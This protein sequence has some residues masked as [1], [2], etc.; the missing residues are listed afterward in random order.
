MPAYRFCR[1]DDIPLLVEAINSCYLPH[2]P[3]QTE[4]TLTHFKKDIRELNLWSSSCMIATDGSKLIAVCLGCKRKKETL[5][6]KI[7]VH[8]D[9]QRQGHGHH[10]LT[11][12]RS[13]LAV[14]GPPR[15]VVEVPKDLTQAA[16]FFKDLGYTLTQSFF[17]FTLT[18]KLPSIQ[19]TSLVSTFD[20]AELLLHKTFQDDLLS[21]QRS[22]ETLLNKKRDL[23]SIA[24]VSVDCIEAYV[25]YEQN[26]GSDNVT[27]LRF[28]AAEGATGT[29]ALGLLIRHLY[30]T[31]KKPFF[32]PK[33]GS[34]EISFD[35][36]ESIGFIR[37]PEY[38]SLEAWAKT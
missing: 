22:D 3:A 13:K 14:L 25:V 5:I 21:W 18:R 9:F 27:I 7:G 33:V 4:T 26:P 16:L 2:F 12:L 10:L 28:Y 30:H 29:P 11:S 8:P 19:N 36:L 15:I 32:A 31:T 34:Q 1:P 17:D 35:V 24:I 20:T 6:H 23:S 38:L 37:G